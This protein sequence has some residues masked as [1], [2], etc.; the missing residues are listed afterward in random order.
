M[1]RFTGALAALLLVVWPA[2]AALRYD[3]IV[4]RTDTR[5]RAAAWIEETIRPGASFC[6][7]LYT[8][9]LPEDRYRVTGDWSLCTQGL[10][11]IA[12]GDCGF[13][14]ASSRMYG[15]YLVDPGAHP[16]MARCYGFLFERWP[17]LREFRG[18]EVAEHDP[19]IRVM[20]VPR[21]D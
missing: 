13:A 21:D 9:E 16:E 14:I 11:D 18:H 6:V 5:A 15:R 20:E 8:P 1:R 10:R 2:S 17:L 19:V 4:T 7:E 3:W 12:E